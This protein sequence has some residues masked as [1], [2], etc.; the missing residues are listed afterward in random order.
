MA[1][2][3]KYL[4]KCTLLQACEWIAFKWRPMLPI[5]ENAS[6]RVRPKAEL[7]YNEKTGCNEQGDAVYHKYNNAIIQARNLLSAHIFQKAIRVIG[8]ADLDSFKEQE[9]QAQSGL[10][11]PEKYHG[12]SNE[13]LKSA[14]KSIA[15]LSKLGDKP[16]GIDFPI[17]G[18]L[19]TYDNTIVFNDKGTQVAYK[20]IVIDFAELQRELPDTDAPLVRHAI[21]AYTTPYI[22]IMLEV[23]AE[24]E[25]A[26]D[27]QSK[28]ELLKNIIADK[29]AVAGLDKSDKIA[30]AMATIIRMPESQKGRAKKS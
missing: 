1:L 4:D 7:I 25:I 21:G 23:I 13:R 19:H 14:R 29:M 28:K 30:D 20:N 18:E 16:I 12:D 8:V 27:N 11:L 2:E 9:K 17:D 10:T 15:K 26:N 22:N 6:G 3:L 5:Y 24:Q